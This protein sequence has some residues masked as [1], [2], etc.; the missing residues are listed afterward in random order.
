MI[1]TLENI[2][3]Y[4]RNQN[5]YVILLIGFILFIIYKVVNSTYVE[6]E[7]KNGFL[8][9]KNTVVK[10]YIS[11]LIGFSCIVLCVTF[12]LSSSLDIARDV[13]E[14][15]REA[16]I[17]MQESSHELMVSYF[18]SEANFQT[19]RNALSDLTSE[20]ERQEAE[21]LEYTKDIN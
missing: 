15:K 3:N 17:Q 21:W 13:K 10:D 19:A 2:L 14:K 18:G 4:I 11:L 16:N 1:N 12:I 20:I 6:T 8:I 9:R 7:V 5:S